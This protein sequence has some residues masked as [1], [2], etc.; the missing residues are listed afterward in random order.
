MALPAEH[1]PLGG[2]LNNVRKREDKSV[3][4][5]LPVGRVDVVERDKRAK[6]PLLGNMLQ[7]VQG[8]SGSKSPVD[9]LLKQANEF[10]TLAPTLQR[11]RVQLRL[12]HDQ[13]KRDVLEHALAPV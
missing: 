1:H 10:G 9:V 6:T 4:S 13:V 12:T 2:I 11:I 8:A 7:R 5:I 3:E